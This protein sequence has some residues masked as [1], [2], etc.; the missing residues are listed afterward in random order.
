MPGEA[1][2]T[3]FLLGTA[4]VMFGP[5]AEVFD[6]TPAD[7]GCGLMKS[8]SVTAEPAFTDLTQGVKNNNVYSIMTGNVVKASAEIYEY[9]ASNLL[10]AT[11][12]NGG[13][14]MAPTGTS[15]LATA[16]AAADTSIEVETG[17]GTN[18]ATGDWIVVEDGATDK[19]V[20]RKVAS[21]AV[22]VITLEA[23]ALAN[24]IP[25]GSKVRAKSM[26]EVGSK[27]DQPF[28][29]CKI[30]GSLANG[31]TLGLIFPKVRIT[32]GFNISFMTDD[33]QNMPFEM[34]MYDLVTS[35]PQYATF[36]GA[37]GMAFV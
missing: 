12:L 10:Y 20:V 5:P 30:V 21:V 35:D 7:H 13:T 33:F 28:F 16:A 6:L 2:T 19:I 22:D 4:T 29:G 24:P 17:D 26:I 9:T 1:K 31:E 11:G 18:F 23:P 25:A 32:N 15:T 3:D 36:G 14:H 8:V 27:E 34:T 37:Q